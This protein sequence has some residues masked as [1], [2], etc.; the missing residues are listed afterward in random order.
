MFVKSSALILFS[1]LLVLMIGGMNFVQAEECEKYQRDDGKIICVYEITAQKLME[2]GWD[3]IEIVNDQSVS[4][5]IEKTVEEIPREKS[6]WIHSVTDLSYMDLEKISNPTGYWVP[7]EDGDTFAQA[8]AN[9]TGDK[10]SNENK[11]GLSDYNTENG[12]IRVLD[13][14]LLN[15]VQPSVHYEMYDSFSLVS[16][17]DQLPFINNFMNSMGFKLAN[18]KLSLSEEFLETCDGDYFTYFC[19]FEDNSTMSRSVDS[20]NISYNLATQYSEIK[21]TFYDHSHILNELAGISIQFNGWTNNP[22]LV[23]HTLSEK[24]ANEKAREFILSTEYFHKLGS[25]GGTCEAELNESIPIRPIVISG[26]PF[27]LSIMADCTIFTDNTGM[28]D[29]PIILI[30]GWTGDYVFQHYAGGQD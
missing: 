14:Y 24:A 21:F 8:L 7:I 28:Q 29:W 11:F 27:Y 17:D 25:D 2:R 23:Q 20:G 5:V 3:I 6:S 26:V 4:T 16:E 22:E 19:T 9:A 13:Y 1:S 18:D 15:V 30:D 12:K 10:L